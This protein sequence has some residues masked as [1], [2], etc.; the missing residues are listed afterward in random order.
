[1]KVRVSF[2][3]DVDD[4]IRRG[5]RRWYG[6]EGLATRQEVKDWYEAYGSSMD[7]DLSL[8]EQEAQ[9]EEAPPEWE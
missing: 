4:T 5:I 8:Q 9:T 6:K 2:V 1:M 3:V 7:D